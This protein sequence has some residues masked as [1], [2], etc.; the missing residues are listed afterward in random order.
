MLVDEYTFPSGRPLAWSGDGLHLGFVV[1]TVILS[2][3]RFRIPPVVPL[4]FTMWPD[5][6]KV[7]FSMSTPI[8]V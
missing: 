6:S 5:A 8:L 7:T 1:T 4:A 3:G 2:I